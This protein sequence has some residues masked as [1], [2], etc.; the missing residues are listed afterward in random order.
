MTRYIIGLE[1]DSAKAV[2][3]ATEITNLALSDTNE[4]DLKQK[5][6]AIVAELDDDA[7]DEIR[8]KPG[9]KYIEE[10]REDVHPHV[11]QKPTQVSSEA[12]VPWGIERIG[13][14]DVEEHGDGVDIAILDTGSDPTHPDLE[15]GEGI[16]I[17]ECEG[18]DC[19]EP[20]DDG[21]DY[22][23]GTH[24]AGTVGALN[25]DLGV[26]GVAPEATLHAVKVMGSSGGSWSDIAEGISKTVDRGWDV[27]NMSFGSS[28]TSQAVKD[29][30]EM[31]YEEGTVLV[32]SAGNEGP[33]ENCVGEPAALP[34]VIAVSATTMH[35]GFAP[36][37]SQGP[38]ID[39]AA[40]GRR[41][42]STLPGGNYGNMNGTSMA[43]PHVAGTAGVLRGAGYAASEVHRLL[44]A[45]AEDIGLPPNKQGV[46]L[47]NV[48]QSMSEEPQEPDIPTVHVDL[49][50][51]KKTPDR[52]GIEATVRDDDGN[53]IDGADIGIRGP[54]EDN[55]LSDE[56]SV[57]FD[58][59]PRGTYAIKAVKEDH[60]PT[61]MVI[62][63]S[64]W[65]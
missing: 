5:G 24:V 2:S 10:D 25:N 8:E 19:T 44:S 45:G 17:N 3:T 1:P 13:A 27:I 65:P 18:E 41:V 14:R 20:W 48:K 47:L 55:K 26:I 52:V 6:R 58:D 34:E 59:L 56:G 50:L 9:V 15:L 53:L 4:I 57:V 37:S 16:G 54:V 11:V 42:R 64:E 46:G 43:A 39:L 61:E 22:G 63:E 28:G 30:V 32:S 62:D 31:A 35:D 60:N 51:E 33:C 23:H 29:A 21:T 38:N 36:F 7:A 12:L 49:V 40:P